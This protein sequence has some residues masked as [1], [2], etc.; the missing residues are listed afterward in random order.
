MDVFFSASAGIAAENQREAVTWA[1]YHL[2]D[3][4][5]L[6]ASAAHQRVLERSG[7]NLRIEWGSL[8]LA[9]P[10]ESSELWPGYWYKAFRNAAG[11]QGQAG[12]RLPERDDLRMPRAAADEEPHLCCL[13][14]FGQVQ[15]QPVSR[16][17]MVAYDDRFSIEYFYQKLRPY[18]RRDGMDVDDLLQAAH[19]DYDRLAERARQFDLELMTDLSQVGGEHYAVLCALAYRQCVAAHKLVAGPDGTPLFFSKENFSNGCIATVDVTYPSSPFFLLLNPLLLKGMLTPVLD[20]RLSGRWHFPFAP[21]DLGQYPLANGQVYGGGERSEE[22]QMPVEES[23]NM[24][25]LLAALA[26][27]DGNADYARRYWDLLLEWAEYLR[28][29]GLDPENQLCTDDF[30]GHLAHNTNLSIKAI[31]GLGG[32]AQLA[33]LAGETQTADEYRAAAQQMAEEWQR[34]A[35]DGDH[36]RL[37]FDRPDTWSQKYNLFWDDLLGLNLFPRELVQ[38]EIAYYLA[39]Q[40]TYGLPLDSRK[41]YTKLDWIIW[42]A[43]LADSDADFRAFLM[44]LVKWA[45]ETPDRVP[46]ADWFETTDGR[47]YHFRARS[48]VGGVFAK[49][50]TNAGLWQKW[51]QKAARS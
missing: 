30:A 34:K 29:K 8:F 23:G 6:S 4:G 31:L 41:T 7:D 13:L 50:L 26:K 20:Y 22:N 1:R 40:N 45:A 38:K 16:H 10:V 12:R 19:S 49:A 11:S 46:L 36:Y 15:E 24:L 37:T 33:D 18:W 9:A 14:H 32:F 48:V 42:T 43:S 28:D 35:A 3:L 51:S 17:V 5:V 27:V 47:H 2:G 44:P 21:H 39:H 25:I